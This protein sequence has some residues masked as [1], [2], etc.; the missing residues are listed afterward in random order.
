[1]LSQNKFHHFSKFSKKIATQ[2]KQYLDPHCIDPI[3]NMVLDY[4]G[5]DLPQP[6]TTLVE[7]LQSSDQN[8]IKMWK[9]LGAVLTGI[10]L[11][12]PKRGPLPEALWEGDYVT[13]KEWYAKG[14]NFIGLDV[15]SC[16]NGRW[17]VPYEALI[18][19]DYQFFLSLLNGQGDWGQVLKTR[20]C[21]KI[22]G[23]ECTLLQLFLA[24]FKDFLSRK[25][26]KFADTVNNIFLLL[27]S[28]QN[29]LQFPKNVKPSYGP[30]S[31]AIQHPDYLDFFLKTINIDAYKEDA[32][33]ALIKSL[34]EDEKVILLLLENK[35]PTHHPL[36]LN[37]FLTRL[38]SISKDMR[39]KIIPLFLKNGF[40]ITKHPAIIHTLINQRLPADVIHIFFH[41]LQE[42]NMNVSYTDRVNRLTCINFARYRNCHQLADWMEKEIV[43][44]SEKVSISF[45]PR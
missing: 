8:I 40:D 39:E 45:R 23:E 35:F 34:N 5:N 41:A 29:G 33:Q 42:K 19:E 22:V 11:T 38:P 1:M 7:A 43:K 4:L 10:E 31:L 14:A 18:A 26:D 30:F 32:S 36:L 2:T 28:K 25:G 44:N 3:Q 24:S 27:A 16:R 12:H 17:P 13:V 6:E 20:G 21:K 9:D 15:M 37:K